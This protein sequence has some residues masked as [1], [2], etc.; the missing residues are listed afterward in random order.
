MKDASSPRD[1]G[2]PSETIQPRRGR[3]SAVLDHAMLAQLQNPDHS[4]AMA[5]ELDDPAFLAVDTLHYLSGGP[6]IAPEER[7]S[8]RYQCA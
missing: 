2:T 6:T 3:L 5:E 4:H 7:E 1:G 8:H